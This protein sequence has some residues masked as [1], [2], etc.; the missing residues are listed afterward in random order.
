MWKVLFNT[1]QLREWVEAA[2]TIRARFGIE[3]ALGHL[4]GEKL[5]RV[6]STRHY[7]KQLVRMIAEQ[8]KK[9]GYNPIIETICDNRRIVND[10]DKIYE[11]NI[12]FAAD[13]QDAVTRFAALIKEA[14]E[15]HEI[16]SYFESN[17]QLGIHGHIH[18]RRIMTFSSGKVQLNIQ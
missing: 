9:P 15:P 1:R 11:D 10:F 14:F 12:I 13:T 2:K 7:H 16:R 18:P 17:P 4:I 3:K 6:V 8:K 5:Y